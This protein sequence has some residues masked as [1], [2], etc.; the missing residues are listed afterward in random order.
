MI[1]QKVVDYTKN[2]LDKGYSFEQIKETLLKSGY[3]QEHIDELRS[4]LDLSSQPA[5]K[6]I[7]IMKI[8]NHAGDYFE[9][10]KP[11]ANFKGPII[12]F[13]FLG[14]ISGLLN[15]ASTIF[16]YFM[17][18]SYLGNNALVV[19]LFGA[20]MTTVQLIL[21]V[22]L[23]IVK[24]LAFSLAGAFIYVGILYLFMKIF[25][26]KGRFV[27]LFHAYSHYYLAMM[28]IAVI[29]GVLATGTGIALRIMSITM[30]VYVLFFLIFAL[31]LLTVMVKVVG[32]L[33]TFKAILVWL[34]PTLIILGSIFAFVFMLVGA[35]F[36][37]VRLPIAF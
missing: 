11:R 22:V 1:S 25:G 28:I 26:S 31:Y 20:Q 9:N 36:S 35:F 29:G 15:A 32:R 17:M 14:L 30:F 12:I 8:F 6:K 27:E 37:L 16:T 19:P 7:S 21:S 3:A 10:I 2:L 23:S 34:F 13:L 5:S 33:G 24:G 18:R 4:I